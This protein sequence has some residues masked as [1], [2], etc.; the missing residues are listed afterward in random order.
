MKWG[1]VSGDL[2]QVSDHHNIIEILLK[3]VLNTISPN[4]QVTETAI[5]YLLTLRSLKQ[6]YHIS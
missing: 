5:P 1:L 6:Q 4:P 3:V 2:W